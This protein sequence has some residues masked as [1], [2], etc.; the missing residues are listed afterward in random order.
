MRTKFEDYSQ[1]MN[2]KDCPECEG[3]GYDEVLNC[4]AASSSDCCGGCYVEKTCKH[5]DGDKTV[6]DEDQLLFKIDAFKRNR[7]K[8]EYDP[9][10]WRLSCGISLDKL[11]R[12]I[13]PDRRLTM[14]Y[15]YQIKKK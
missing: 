12:I 1:F 3:K 14:H 8:R 9:K 4:R 15:W 6:I 10:Y 13:L 2:I 11:E 5:C 7:F